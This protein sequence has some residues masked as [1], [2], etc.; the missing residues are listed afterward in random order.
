MG[1]VRPGTGLVVWVG[2]KVGLRCK[3]RINNAIIDVIRENNYE[4]LVQC[5]NM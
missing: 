1:K 5:K 3:G 4:I 2:L